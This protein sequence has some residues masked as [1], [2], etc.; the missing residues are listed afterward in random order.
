MA[1]GGAGWRGPG[2]R[3]DRDKAIV[4]FMLLL[5]IPDATPRPAVFSF[6]QPLRGSLS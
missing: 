4:W 2:V 3:Q 1:A 6:P 5:E